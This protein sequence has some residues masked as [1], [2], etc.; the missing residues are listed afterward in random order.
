MVLPN[1]QKQNLKVDL[2]A[3]TVAVFCSRYGAIYDLSRCHLTEEEVK[4]GR[5]LVF[6][7]N[8]ACELNLRAN[9]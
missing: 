1:R 4:Y 6:T 7:K 8:F 5:K 2:S 3:C 9:V